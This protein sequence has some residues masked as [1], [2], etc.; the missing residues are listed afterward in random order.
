MKSS[1]PN[2][3]LYSVFGQDTSM[4]SVLRMFWGLKESLVFGASFDLAECDKNL[5]TPK[6]LPEV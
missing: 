5:D 1:T 4:V 2:Q 3:D 6:R